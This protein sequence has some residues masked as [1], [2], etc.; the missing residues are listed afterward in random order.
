MTKKN[1][2]VKKDEMKCTG[3]VLNCGDERVHEGKGQFINTIYLIVWKCLT[4]FIPNNIFIYE[5]YLNRID[6]KKN[7]KKR[8]FSLKIDFGIF[9]Q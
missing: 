1:L 5:F 9:C 2:N 6:Q 7:L 3:I 8:T 4:Y